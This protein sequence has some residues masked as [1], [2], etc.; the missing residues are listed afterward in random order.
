[1][2][3]TIYKREGISRIIGFLYPEGYR[4]YSQH[5]NDTVI[6]SHLR[7]DS[8]TQRPHHI[9]KRLAQ[10][11]NILYVEEPL[12]PD[13]FAGLPYRIYRPETGITVLQPFSSVPTEEYDYA[14]LINTF[15]QT[16]AFSDTPI[17][18]LYSPMFVDALHYLTPSLVI[19]DC[20]DKLSQFKFAPSS[21]VEKEHM[22][23]S[24]ADIVFTGGKSL[25]E[26]LNR[27]HE[28]AYCFPSSVDSR[29]FRKAFDTET[30]FPTD[31]LEIPVPRVGFI[32]V[33]DERM[34][35]DLVRE[36]AKA[37]P[38]VSFVFI[39]PVVKIDPGTLPR[40]KN[41]RY[42][43]P[44]DYSALPNYLKGIDV[45]WMP[46]AL[47][48]ATQFISPTKTLEFIAAEKPIVSTAVHD[49]VRDY[50]SVVRIIANPEEARRAIAGLLNENAVERENR[51][52]LEREITAGTS[53]DKTV[54]EMKAIIE[55]TA[56]EK[57]MQEPEISQ[58]PVFKLKLS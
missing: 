45:T 32:G 58:R 36:T 37:M 28:S 15:L 39:G 51:I 41:I 14:S 20:M 56:A 5:L 19:Y 2:K 10:D 4:Q 47:N 21:L 6:F 31:L 26:D 9:A 50:R 22:L 29:H 55:D 30:V 13:G 18:W 57:A 40:L 33:I 7:W 11:R 12:P 1:M 23:L 8:I 49:V 46:F 53:W 52:L 38:D 34:D 17:Y 48:G 3:K 43:G 16:T 42:L 24:L 27:R 25:Y 35:L 44:R 54:E